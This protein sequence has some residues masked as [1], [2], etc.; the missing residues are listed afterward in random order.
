ME[1]H[2]VVVDVVVV[3]FMLLICA[4]KYPEYLEVAPRECLSSNILLRSEVTFLHHF[5]STHSITESSKIPFNSVGI[6][7]EGTSVLRGVF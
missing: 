1:S 6:T 7:R 4:P 5:L 2:A 3:S